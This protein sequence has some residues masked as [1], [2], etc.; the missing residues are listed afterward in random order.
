MSRTLALEKDNVD[1][2]RSE[3]LNAAAFLFATKGYHAA[4]MRELAK[5][6][7]IKAGSLY[8]HIASK[9]QLLGEICIIGM[10]AVTHNVDE[11]IG[12]YSALSDRIRAIVSGHER[13]IEGF[14]NYFH[15]YENENAHLAPSTREEIRLALFEFHRKIDGIFEDATKNGEIRPDF[16]VKTSRFALIAMLSQLSRLHS[17]QHHYDLHSVAKDFADTLIDGFAPR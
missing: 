15:C 2:R 1:V 17:D 4:S 10:K 5:H 7:E 14:G 13:V 8:Y 9:E 11:A 12:G 6:L 3:L 16:N